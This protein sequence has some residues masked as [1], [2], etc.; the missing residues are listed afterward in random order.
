MFNNKGA[1]EVT[2]KFC[3]RKINKIGKTKIYSAK[4]FEPLKKKIDYM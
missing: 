3:T 2:T 1:Y 4:I